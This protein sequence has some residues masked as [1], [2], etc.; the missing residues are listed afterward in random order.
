MIS[1]E[2]DWRLRDPDE[3]VRDL[4]AA[5]EAGNVDAAR[6]LLQQPGV[7]ADA[8]HDDGATLTYVAAAHGH[9]AMVELLADEGGAD[10][11][12][13]TRD[14]A[15]ALLIESWR[16]NPP[17]Q[18]RRDKIDGGVYPLY[19]AARNGRAD[20]VRALTER[21]V[22][23]NRAKVHGRKFTP[24]FGAVLDS[25]NA[26]VVAIL[27]ENG[28]D[29]NQAMNNG[30]TP[31]YIASQ[32]GHTAALKLLI[33]NGGDVNQANNDGATPVLIASQEGHTAALQLLIQNGGDANQ[34]MNEGVTPV[35]ITSQKGHTAALKL[36]IENG[37]D[38]NQADNRGIAPVSVASQ[39][40]HTAAL[41]LLLE[42]GGDVNQADNEGIAPVSVASQEGHTAALKLLL[43]NGGNVNQATNDGRTPVYTAAENGHTAAIKLLLKAGADVHKPDKD[44]TPPVWIAAD[45]GHTDALHTLLKAGA[46]ARTASGFRATNF[47]TLA[48][49]SATPAYGDLPTLHIAAHNGRLPVVRVLAEIWPLDRR[50]W[51]MFLMGAGAASELQD[52]LAPPANRATRNFLPR[53]YSK[54]DMVKEVWKYLHKPRYVDVGQ[55]DRHG[56]TAAQVAT[57]YGK[58]DVAALLQGLGV[59]AGDDL[60]R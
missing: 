8:Y 57:A 18:K 14:D 52:Y 41:K 17:T 46:N 33:D 35:Y 4:R 40:G 21:G 5:V 58:D 9:T 51:K 49:S 55:L 36:L 38:V 43:E 31:V 16:L 7:D 24:L 29:V 2:C 44:G 20:T 11:S 60:R 19:I 26:D 12:K 39:Q 34:A 1:D 30:S 23:V 56:R 3:D 59:G 45:H 25:D 54:P 27:L 13:A 47:F 6:S 53:L 10:I 22:D 48:L 37:G 15:K 28:G 42:N 32:E 50:A